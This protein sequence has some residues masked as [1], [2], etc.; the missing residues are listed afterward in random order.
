MEK[1][2]GVQRQRKT[3]SKPVFEASYVRGEYDFDDLAVEYDPNNYDR[4]Y[5][6]DYGVESF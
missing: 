4:Q 5:D 3:R 2:T 1:G 6:D